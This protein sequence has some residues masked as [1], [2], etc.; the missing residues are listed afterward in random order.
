MVRLPEDVWRKITY[1]VQH[2]EWLDHRN[3]AILYDRMYYFPKIFQKQYLREVLKD[4]I[5]VKNEITYI[6]C[7]NCNMGSYYFN[8]VYDCY[9]QAPTS[10]N[11][12]GIIDSINAARINN[13][14]CR[15]K[16]KAVQTLSRNKFF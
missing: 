14:K 6:R 11:W 7:G 10:K 1:Q 3:D 12:Q 8:E 9:C 15:L 2:L 16:Q 4:I 5:E 13:K